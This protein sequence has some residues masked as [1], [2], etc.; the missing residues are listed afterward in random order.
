MPSTTQPVTSNELLSDQAACY[1]ALSTR[2]ARF[3]GR[4]FVGVSSTGIYCRPVCRVRLPKREN[5]RFFATAAAA[6]TDGFRPCLRCRPELAPG[7]SS[8]DISAQLAYAA[9]SQLDATLHLGDGLSAV[10]AHLGVSQ[11]HLRRIFQQHLGVAPRDYLQT[12]R[13]LLAK[14]LLSD[15]D[16]SIADVAAAAG[17]NSQRR[18]NAS[19]QQRYRMTPSDL[20]QHRA[21]GTDSSCPEFHLSVR[22]PYDFLWLCHFFSARA[23]DGLEQVGNNYYQRVISVPTTA[24][25]RLGWLRVAQDANGL[26]LSI[27]AS[28]AMAVAPVIALTRQLFDLDTDPQPLQPLAQALGSKHPGLRVPGS[29]SGFEIA[30]RAILGQQITVAAARTLAG[31]F[32]SEFG[33]RCTF[34]DCREL[35]HAFPEPAVIAAAGQ[36]QIAALGIIGRRA[37]TIRALASAIEGQHLDLTP[38]GDVAATLQ[39]LTAIRGIGDW[40]AQYIAMRALRWP[41]AFP[42]ADHG[43]MKA[44]NCRTAAQ[45]RQAA[46][47][48]RPWRAYAVMHLWAGGGIG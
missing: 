47:A 33:A 36:S 18:L 15:T 25:R 35:T 7:W 45:A 41:D 31:R 26:K 32:V 8:Q 29:G 24:G 23:I 3:D 10:A 14:R 37:E 4:L 22:E 19:M 11:R 40:T 2:D 42:A 39:K 27:S 16:M 46:H 6:E 43:V 5:C 21:G 34:T 28:L 48:W 38:G 44:L 17:F 20:R 30:V 13:L 9:A 1:R 12:Q